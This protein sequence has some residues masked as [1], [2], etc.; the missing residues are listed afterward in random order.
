[1]KTIVETHNSG[2]HRTSNNKTPNEV[3]NYDDNQL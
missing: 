3:F 1:M 2:S